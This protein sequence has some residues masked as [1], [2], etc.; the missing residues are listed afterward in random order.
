[1]LLDLNPLLIKT[2]GAYLEFNPLLEHIIYKYWGVLMFL[3]RRSC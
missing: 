1:M 2:L 3:I